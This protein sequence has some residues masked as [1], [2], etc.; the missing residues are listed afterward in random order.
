MKNKKLNMKAFTLAEVLIVLSVIGVLTI[1]SLGV[2]TNALPDKNKSIFKKT[3][4]VLEK[5]VAELVNDEEYYPYDPGFP[6]FINNVPVRI[7]LSNADIVIGE[8]TTNPKFEYLLYSKLNT[9]DQ[10]A[11]D[12]DGCY[13]TT[14][15]GV[16][17]RIHP[18]EFAKSPAEARKKLITVDVNGTE[19]GPNSAEQN[20][21][22]DIFEIYVYFDGK[23][24]VE[25][26][27]EKKYLSSQ[28]LKKDD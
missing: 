17:W 3:Y 13:F 11:F 1:L 28:S 23:V 12:D 15:D 14:S 19:K 4:S 9:M 18:G 5:T 16:F 6:G 10:I 26:D 20:N 21:N 8:D 2:F 27:M 25:G 7:S 24:A 22:K